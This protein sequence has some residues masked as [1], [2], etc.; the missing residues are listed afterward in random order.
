MMSAASIMAPKS[1]FWSAV[2]RFVPVVLTVPGYEAGSATE[3]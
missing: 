1:T 3:K 2:A